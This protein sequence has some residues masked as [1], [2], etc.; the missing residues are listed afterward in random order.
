MSDTPPK[1][2]PAKTEARKKVLEKAIEDRR[3]GCLDAGLRQ[4]SQSLRLPTNA[5]D[6]QY[7]EPDEPAQD[8]I[9]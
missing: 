2:Q 5:L 8:L 4:A 9:P 6:W 7:G 3:A 1:L